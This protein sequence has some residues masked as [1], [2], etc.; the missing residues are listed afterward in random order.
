[1]MMMMMKLPILDSYFSL[2]HQNQ[3]L[4]PTSR[5]ETVNVPISRGGQCGVPM[6]RDLSLPPLHFLVLSS[7]PLLSLSFTILFIILTVLPLS[8]LS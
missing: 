2:P 4:K 1:M 7:S 3:E 5:V 6:M 8:R